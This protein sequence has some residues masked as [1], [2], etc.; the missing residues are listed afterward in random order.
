MKNKVGELFMPM[1]LGPTLIG[2]AAM[3]QRAL[4]TESR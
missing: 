3:F 2:Y 1:G 4:V